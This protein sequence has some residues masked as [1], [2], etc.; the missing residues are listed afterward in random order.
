MT[1]VLTLD[2]HFMFSH[3]HKLDSVFLGELCKIF[4]STN[5]YGSIDGGVIAQ[6]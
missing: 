6:I 2:A 5:L 4:H 1:R 3:G